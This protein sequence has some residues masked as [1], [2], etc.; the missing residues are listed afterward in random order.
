MY[1][2][3]D[4]TIKSNV[5]TALQAD[6]REFRQRVTFGHWTL[7]GT[8]RTFVSDDM[9]IESGITSLHISQ[10]SNG[11][12]GGLL[13]GCCCSSCAEAEFYNPNKSYNYSGK[14]MFVES[15]I[16]LSDG[17]FYYIPLGYYNVEAPESDDDW[18]TVRIKAYD[19]V[20]QMT[21]KWTTTLTY[22]AT[23][24][25]VLTELAGRYNLSLHWPLTSYKTNLATNKKITAEQ[26]NILANYADREV[27]GFLAGMLG[28]NA[29]MNTVGKLNVSWYYQYVTVNISASLQWQNGF[30]KTFESAF[31]VSSITSGIND[32]VFTSGTGKG[33]TFSN[34]IITQTEVTAIYNRFKSKTFQPCQ[35]EW[36]GNP[37]VEAGDIVTVTDKNDNTYTVFIAEQEIDLTGGL[38]MSITCPPGDADISFDTVDWQTMIEL[39]KQKNEL[40]QAIEKAT[41]AINGAKGGYYEILDSDNDGNPDGWIIKENEGGTSGIIR[42]NKEGIGLSQDGGKTYKT[43]ITYKGIA[44]EAIICA[45]LSA[46]GATIGGWNIGDEAIYKD[47][48]GYRA[49]LQS[50]NV[51]GLDTW[52]LSA[53]KLDDLDNPNFYLTMRGELYLASNFTTV[54]KATFRNNIEIDMLN[55]SYK[56]RVGKGSDVGA[57]GKES[58]ALVLLD[59]GNYQPARLDFYPSTDP[60]T[61]MIRS[62]VKYSTGTKFGYM[63]L[64]NNYIT[65]GDWESGNYA[66]MKAASF[67]VVS[68]DEV[69]TNITEAGSAL[70]LFEPENSQIYSYNLKKTVTTPVEGGGDGDVSLDGEGFE[71][72][73]EVEETASYG[74]VI[75]D[76]YAVPEQ[77]LNKEG[78]AISLYSM[79]ALTWKAVQEL[80][81][82]IK[83]LE[84]KVNA[85]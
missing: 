62:T 69:K 50:P 13:M 27:L 25:S 75:G 28:F 37:C 53:Q 10:K 59:R 3:S 78:N 6:T 61:V 12:S 19:D 76:G 42:A 43:A 31:T 44:A 55:E 23:L 73:E 21:S 64:S 82:K 32:A 40:Q 83:Q 26:A 52:I 74:F 24:L 1:I 30:K 85:Q 45:D 58:A 63:S 39:R 22:P 11:D 16:K 71:I 29:R 54:G 47:S 33:I 38:S 4:T 20:Y 80:N 15:G 70:G 81:S 51:A 9:K 36:R 72:T 7:S 35:C 77:V 57:Y 41:N 17:S 84:E 14:V 46:I 18:Y 5:E 34:P 56:F 79:A 60:A 8:V 68:V 2:I 66:K 48:G 67:D 65:A 49:Y